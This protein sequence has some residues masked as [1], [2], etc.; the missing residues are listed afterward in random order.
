MIL[1]KDTVIE[2]GNIFPDLFLL[3]LAYYPRKA[4]SFLIGIIIK[5]ISS[6]Y[7][8]FDFRVASHI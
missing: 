4:L 5:I 7:K 3:F 1:T 6:A 8:V 2:L